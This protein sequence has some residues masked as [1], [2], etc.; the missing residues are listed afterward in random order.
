M[1]HIQ[2]DLPR[3]LTK[4]ILGFIG[5]R[6]LMCI[7][8]HPLVDHELTQRKGALLEKTL[9]AAIQYKKLLYEIEEKSFRFHVPAKQL[10]LYQNL[11]LPGKIGDWQCAVHQNLERRA[12]EQPV[13][14]RALTFGAS[15][16]DVDREVIKRWAMTTVSLLDDL[17]A[18]SGIPCYLRHCRTKLMN[19]L[20][21]L[22]HT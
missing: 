5:S 4:H 8:K 16:T 10:R 18:L 12:Y 19:G 14:D 22:S 9:D 7:T 2:V 17:I 20:K 21:R 13:G 11:I 3:D 6:E 15:F 1:K